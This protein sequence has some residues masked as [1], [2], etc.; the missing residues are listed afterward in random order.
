MS[1]N[2]SGVLAAIALALAG[3]GAH[4]VEVRDWPVDGR[5]M[6]EF[7]LGRPTTVGM[8]NTPGEIYFEFS[9]PVGAADDLERLAN[10]YAGRIRGV[11]YGRNSIL[12]EGEPGVAFEAWQTGRGV[13]VAVDGGAGPAT[14]ALDEKAA[15]ERRLDVLRGRVALATGRPEAAKDVLEAAAAR[16]P[17]DPAALAALAAAEN[18]LGREDR[19]IAYLD[20]AIAARPDDPDLARERARIERD[21]AAFVEAY[22]GW[23]DT[24]DADRQSR[25]GVRV[26]ARYD[27]NWRLFGEAEAGHVRS[28]AEQRI[29]GG[30]TRIDEGYGRGQL[31]AAYRWSDNHETEGSLYAAGHGPGAGLVHRIGPATSE[32]RFAAVYAEPYFDDVVGIVDEGRRSSLT[33]G[34]DHRFD[35]DWRAGVSGGVY[36]YG[37]RGDDDVAE[38]AGVAANVRRRL[39][40]QAPFYVDAGYSFEGEYVLDVDERL[41][42][43]GAIFNPLPIDDREIHFADVSASAALA[44][45][46]S[47]SATVGYG[48]DRF[49]SDGAT[50]AL[51]LEWEPTPD[52]RVGVSGSHSFA[53]AR[54]EDDAVTNVGFFVRRRLG[55]PLATTPA[56][57]TLSEASR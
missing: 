10:A 50:F 37:V 32:A 3:G 7:D 22:G 48:F 46:I 47:A 57:A 26:R 52:W 45:T 11:R 25:A 19:A 56:P 23:R 54:G 28:D 18:E 8:R 12:I 53:A 4:A 16:D 1:W 20:R 55:A 36:L 17:N 51:A 21:R 2:A 35:R 39:Y 33:A 14:A 41:N 38:T 6:V 29:G 49:G 42:A 13:R 9:A 34:Y 24:K 5:L 44:P 30:V 27:R 31:G 15:A 43:A 40:S